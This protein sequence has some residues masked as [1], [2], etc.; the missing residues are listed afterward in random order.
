MCETK[1]TRPSLMICSEIQGI[2]GPSFGKKHNKAVQAFP[3]PIC[4]RLFSSCL[5]SILFGSEII[6][7]NVGILVGQG[8]CWTTKLCWWIAS[9]RCQRTWGTWTAER[10]GSS[11]RKVWR[12]SKLFLNVGYDQC[13]F[14]NVG[15]LMI[16]VQ[17][18]H[19]RCFCLRALSCWLASIVFFSHIAG[20]FRPRFVAGM[21]EGGQ[22]EWKWVMVAIR[23]P[24]SDRTSDWIS[25][26]LIIIFGS[27]FVLSLFFW[28]VG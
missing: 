7:R 24:Q 22:P 18:A 4:G 19:F 17:Y 26:Q 8:I 11:G 1:G 3:Q 28:V 14:Q 12:W 25:D 16:L 10:L 23:T 13:L 2:P 5:P 27:I 6:T 21:V 20:G 15:Y 9:S